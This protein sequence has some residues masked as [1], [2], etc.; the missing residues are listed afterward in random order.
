[1]TV[2]E[3]RE[4]LETYPD[5]LRVV[6]NGYEQGYDDVSPG[7]I[8]VCAW[9]SM[10]EWEDWEGRH[11]EP[12]LIGAD[13]GKPATIRRRAWFFAARPTDSLTSPVTPAQHDLAKK[14]VPEPRAADRSPCATGLGCQ[15]RIATRMGRRSVRRI[16]T[17]TARASATSGRTLRRRIGSSIWRNPAGPFRI[18]CSSARVV[19]P[20]VIRRGLF[21][22]MGEVQALLDQYRTWL[23]DKTTPAPGR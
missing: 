12:D 1:M 5:D 14:H 21:H 23:R 20:P 15:G 3:L 4:L 13:A 2:G 11:E 18:S 8:S 17:S 10:S 22:M 9:H 19:E 7:Q 6:V 16:F